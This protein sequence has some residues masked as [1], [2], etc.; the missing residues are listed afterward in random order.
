MAKKNEMKAIFV[1]RKK[2]N[3]IAAVSDGIMQVDE[4]KYKK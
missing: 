3:I 1:E 2:I 4:L